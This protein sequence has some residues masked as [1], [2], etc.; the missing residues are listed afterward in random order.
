M[1]SINIEE[2]GQTDVMCDHEPVII[3]KSY[4][5]AKKQ[6]MK[7]RN[8]SWQVLSSRNGQKIIDN[9]VA[10]RLIIKDVKGQDPEEL[11]Q[12]GY[13]DGKLVIAEYDGVNLIWVDK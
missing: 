12:I 9:G 3:D 1:K 2:Y 5:L 13:K 11:H 10:N 4:N 6:A 8:R 7:A